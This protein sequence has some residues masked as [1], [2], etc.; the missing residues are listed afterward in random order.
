M[1]T[2]PRNPEQAIVLIRGEGD[3]NAARMFAR[4]ACNLVGMRGYAAQKVVTAVSELARNIC[5][6]VGEGQLRF[7]IDVD[8]N[9]ITV[10]AEDHGGG[11]ADLDLVLSGK[12][13]SRTGLGRGLLGA[14]NLADHFHIETGPE[15]TTVTIAFNF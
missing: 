6:Y 1:A 10:V 3:L 14:K 13:R 2:P 9:R 5:R 12:Y 15:G 11:I 4:E 7:Q 8:S